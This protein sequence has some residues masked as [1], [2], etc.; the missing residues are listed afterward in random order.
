[1]FKQMDPQGTVNIRKSANSKS[2]AIPKLIYQLCMLPTP[3]SNCMDK[4]KD[5]LYKLYG[6]IRETKLKEKR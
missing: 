2:V 1:M 3:S 4:I 6:T 5:L